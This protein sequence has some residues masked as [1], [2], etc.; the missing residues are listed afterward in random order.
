MGRHFW[1][2]LAFA[3]LFVGEASALRGCTKPDDGPGFWWNWWIYATAAFGAV[4]AGGV[5][6]F[7]DRLRPLLSPPRLEIRIR[8]AR[9]HA[10]INRVEGPAA[11]A[12]GMPPVRI[13]QDYPSRWYHL[14]V[15]NGNRRVATVHGVRVMLTEIWAELS[16]RLEKI[17]DE[18]VTMM[19]QHYPGEERTV[20][21]L[22]DADLCFVVQGLQFVRLNTRVDVFSLPRDVPPKTSRVV[23][24]RARGYEVDSE[25]LC[26]EIWWDG[27]FDED[28]ARMAEHLKVRPTDDPAPQSE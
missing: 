23:V 3:A 14:R 10:G 22:V 25:R 8:Q 2:Y 21:A 26:V 9:G 6:M 17:W 11:G 4:F 28:E 18:E 24:F 20:G 1:P 27:Q 15:W 12:P 5:A 19:W 13:S 7:I 16:G